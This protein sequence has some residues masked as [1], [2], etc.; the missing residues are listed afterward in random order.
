MTQSWHFFNPIRKGTDAS[1][2]WIDYI[3]RAGYIAKGAVYTLVGFLAVDAALT[4]SDS[5]GAQGALA[6]IRSA[7][8]GRLLLGLTATG[9]LCYFAWRMIQACWDVENIGTDFKGIVKRIGYF[10]SGAANFA[11]ASVAG[12]A[13]IRGGS[14]SSAED[15]SGGGQSAKEQT[16]ETVMNFPGG[17][18]L[19]ILVGLVVVGVGLYH[20]YKSYTAKFMEE[21]KH[22]EMSDAEC[23]AAKPIGMIGLAARGITF[24][25][26]GGFIVSAGW[27]TNSGKVGGL[28]EAFNT[29]AGGSLGWVLLG[30][31]ALGFV[32]YGVYCF[33]RAKYKRFAKPE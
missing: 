2:Q 6:M 12:M 33:S 27:R 31:V 19:V 28:G 24:C 25:I 23:N 7:P 18:L 22:T 4:A 11:L 14:P 20:F 30:A 26:I 1:D 29:L 32:A 8:F 5:D 16:A 13:A 15:G 21:Y 3:A 9:L 10:V 17:W